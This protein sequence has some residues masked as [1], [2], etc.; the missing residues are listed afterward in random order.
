MNAVASSD[1]QGFLFS[2]TLTS[3]RLWLRFLRLVPLGCVKLSNIR[4]MRRANSSEFWDGGF[5]RFLAFWKTW[6]WPYPLS[7]LGSS[8]SVVFLLETVH[9][10]RVFVRLA[11]GIHYRLRDGINEAKVREH[12]E[13]PNERAFSTSKSS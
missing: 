7:M 6:H 4:S 2:Y 13:A 9:G 3:N 11:P 8:T 12:G 5:L 1:H 10:T